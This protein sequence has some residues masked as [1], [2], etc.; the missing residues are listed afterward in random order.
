MTWDESHAFWSGLRYG[1]NN[2]VLH[3]TAPDIRLHRRISASGNAVFELRVVSI[4]GLSVG[5][6]LTPSPAHMGG[7][8][9][10]VC[11]AG[12]IDQSDRYRK[13]V[14]EYSDFRLSLS[15]TSY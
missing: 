5:P 2:R 6:R 10:F 11:H 9:L 14:G 3:T 15:G 4:R 8:R 13:E 12:P 1:G 7:T